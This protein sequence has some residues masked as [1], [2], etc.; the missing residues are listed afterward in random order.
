MCFPGALFGGIEL[1]IADEL[2]RRFEPVAPWD[3]YHEIFCDNELDEAFAFTPGKYTAIALEITN[4]KKRDGKTLVYRHTITDDLDGIDALLH[5]DNFCILAPVSYAGNS[6][7]SINARV[8]YA[9]CVELDDLKVGAEQEQE[10]L[11]NLVYQWDGPSKVLPRP[12]FCVSSGSGIHLYYVFERPIALFPN[13]VKSLIKYKTELTQRIWNRYVT[14]AY[15]KE[16]IQFESVFQAFRMPGTL[17]KNGERAE[18]FR[19]GEKVS[20]EYMNSF[21]PESYRKKGA[22]IVAAYKSS[23]NLTEAKHKWPDWYERRIVQG[24]KK[25]KKWDIAGKVNGG[26]PYALYDWWYRKISEGA[27]VGKRYYC[28]LMLVV[29]AIKCDVP[30]DKLR[31]DCYRLLDKY[32]AMAFQ[33]ERYAGYD[34][35]QK[36]KK[37]PEKNRFTAKD[38][39][40]ALQAYQDAGLYTYPISS[41]VARSGITIE[42]NRRNGQKQE[43]HLEDI[44]TKKA[45]MKKRGQSF[46][47]PEGRPKGSGTAEQTVAKYRAEHPD[48]SVTAVAKALNMSRTTVYKWW[49][50]VALPDESKKEKSERDELIDIWDV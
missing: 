29:Y 36:K 25:I 13:V 8:M 42:K 14:Y 9:L 43:W 34:R 16:D 28:L 17:T 15:K 38:V 45:Q 4:Q 32:D 19:T 10:G 40:A 22:E 11:W 44:R 41:I 49:D 46:A 18:A 47:N 3:F 26:N 21:I 6:R 24:D 1:I 5:S 31:D 50:S 7:K 27:L 2:S 12:T 23:V 37:D 30:E 20:I 39:E 35:I 48:K 33:P